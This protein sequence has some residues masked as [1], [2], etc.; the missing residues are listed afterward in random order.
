MRQ[1]GDFFGWSW[2]FRSWGDQA[3]TPTYCISDLAIY[4]SLV[5][6]K[7]T[8]SASHDH[9]QPYI[10]SFLPHA[11]KD[12]RFQGQVPLVPIYIVMTIPS[13]LSSSTPFWISCSVAF[14]GFGRLQQML[15]QDASFLPLA[16]YFFTFLITITFFRPVNY[17]QLS[18]FD[19]QTRES[20]Q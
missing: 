20:S 7:E 4:L 14:I 12:C 19:H 15:S 5:I 18:S 8:I 1:L 16:Q 6:E 2:V 10:K 13:R 17:Q 3:L 11:R 9:N